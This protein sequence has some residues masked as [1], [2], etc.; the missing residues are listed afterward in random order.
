MKRPLYIA[1]MFGE[2]LAIF[3][4]ENMLTFCQSDRHGQ[5]TWATCNE[6]EATVAIYRTHDKTFTQV[7]R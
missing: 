3:I 2:E 5:G 7:M 4:S 6:K 1:G